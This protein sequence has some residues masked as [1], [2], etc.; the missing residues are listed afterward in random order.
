M[1]SKLLKTSSDTH[2]YMA[3]MYDIDEIKSVFDTKSTYLPRDDT[4]ARVQRLSTEENLELLPPELEV[5]NLSYST[6]SRMN[7]TG[8]ARRSIE[9]LMDKT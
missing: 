8:S 7:S 9:D 2:R 6:E 4:C 3:T 5:N 1:E